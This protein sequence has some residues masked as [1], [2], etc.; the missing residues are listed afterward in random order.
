[1]TFPIDEGVVQIDAEIDKTSIRQAAQS[2]G[3]QAGDD[4]EKST[5]DSFR[6]SAEGNRGQFSNILRRAITPSADAFQALRAPFAAALSTPIGAAVIA[7]AGVAALAFVG[8]FATALATAGLGAAFLAIGILAVRE[9]AKIQKSFETLGDRV[10]KAFAGAGAPLIQPLVDAMDRLGDA[11]ER[12]APIFKN[13]FAGLAPAIG[14][15]TDGIIG[16]VENFL[17]VLTADPAALQGMKDALVAIGVNLPRVG[18]ELGKLFASLASNEDNVRNIGLLFDAIVL[19]IGFLGAS[20]ALLTTTLDYLVNGWNK[21]IDVGGAVVSWITGTLVPAI[22]GVASAIGGFFTSIPGLISS[23]LSAIGAFFQSLWTSVST[24]VVNLVNTVVGFFTALPGR[25]LG[26]LATLPGMLLAFF[27]GALNAVAFAIGFA[28]GSIVNMWITLPGKIVSAIQAL[29][30]LVAGIFNSVRSTATSI[31]SGLVNAV[32][33]FFSQ[34]PGRA[35]S[36]AVGIVQ[37]I[38]SVFQSARSTAVSTAGQIVSSVVSTLA[39]LPGRAASAVQSV[40]SRIAGALRSAIGQAS[41]IGRQIIQG[42]IN[43]IQAMAGAAVSAAKR[44]VQSAINGAKAALGIGSPSKVFAQIGTD[45]LSGLVRGLSATRPVSKAMAGVVD[46][47]S[48]FGT[49]GMSSPALAGA[50]SA[51]G[52]APV[53]ATV[54]AG[55]SGGRVGGVSI[56]SLQISVGVIDPDRATQAGSDFAEGFAQRLATV[57]TAR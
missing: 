36:A 35:Y 29:P 9:N 1:M 21:V 18:T 55:S 6:K 7:V 49:P 40:G 8:A 57:R 33:S 41:S 30:G 44:V 45:T 15:L 5:R 43:G 24:F 2:A 20:L 47:M 52:V 39:Q 17:K 54:G 46:A 34:L 32:V 38:A 19:S 26:A 14:P 51:G 42:L 11:A 31:V 28:I 23:A 25:I 50:G 16:F 53:R 37:R 10:K 3:Q 4:L 56:G 22:T 48:G 13:I 12:V 27:T